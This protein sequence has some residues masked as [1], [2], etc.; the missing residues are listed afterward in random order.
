MVILKAK[1]QKPL[2]EIKKKYFFLIYKKYDFRIFYILG[3]DKLGDFYASTCG[4]Y[5]NTIN[6]FK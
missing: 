1:W 3:K 6:F 2:L 4:K 5:E